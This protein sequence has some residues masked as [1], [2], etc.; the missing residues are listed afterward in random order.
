MAES[1]FKPVPKKLTF[2]GDK[3]THNFLILKNEESY[4]LLWET[5]GTV[6]QLSSVPEFSSN[7]GLLI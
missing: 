5:T 7:L 3:V 2:L 1:R 6:I 4:K